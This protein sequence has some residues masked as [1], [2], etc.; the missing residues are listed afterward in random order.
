MYIMV[1]MTDLKLPGRAQPVIP[2]NLYLYYEHNS[3][4]SSGKLKEASRLVYPKCIRASY[5]KIAVLLLVYLDI[6]SLLFL[7]LWD[8]PIS[9]HVHTSYLIQ[10]HN[11]LLALYY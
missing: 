11:I 10:V 9:V 8:I 3:L 4:G 2:P 7:S 1:I 6:S 5:C